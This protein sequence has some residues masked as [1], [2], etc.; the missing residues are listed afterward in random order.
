MVEFPGPPDVVVVVWGVVV[1]PEHG[2]LVVVE[3]TGVEV[4]LP[5]LT[6]VEVELPG[7]AGVELEL[8]GLTV[9]EVELPGLA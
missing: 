5:G 2:F 8:P 7:L 9:V 6:V 3:L 1:S 4:E